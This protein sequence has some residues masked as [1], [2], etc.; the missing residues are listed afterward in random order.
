MPRVAAWTNSWAVRVEAWHFLGGTIVWLVLV[1]QFRQRRLAQEE[2]L[3]AEH[4]QRLRQEGKDICLIFGLVFGAEEES[5]I[6][7]RPTIPPW[8]EK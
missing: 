8:R 7:L 2:R 6:L 4:Y 5:F 3:D 1:I